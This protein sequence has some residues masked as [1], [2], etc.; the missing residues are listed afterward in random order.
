[1]TNINTLTKRVEKL[2]NREHKPAHNIKIIYKFNKWHVMKDREEFDT[3]RDAIDH[4]RKNY[5]TANVQVDQ[6]D[7]LMDKASVEDLRKMVAIA[8]AEVNDGIPYEPAEGEDDIFKRF[9]EPCDQLAEVEKAYPTM[10]FEIVI[11]D[12]YKELKA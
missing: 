4:V 6:T 10:H 8:D 1:M 12:S 3:L 9:D 11:E 5:S 7:Y 2:E